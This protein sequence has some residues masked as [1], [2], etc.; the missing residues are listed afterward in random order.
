[1]RMASIPVR[2]GRNNICKKTDHFYLWVSV[3]KNR[4]KRL[5]TTLIITNL[6]QKSYRKTTFC[7]Y[8]VFNLVKGRTKSC[9]V[10]ITFSISL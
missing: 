1:M 5:M 3:A 10:A 2:G 6:A 4:I 7:L 9:K 8:L